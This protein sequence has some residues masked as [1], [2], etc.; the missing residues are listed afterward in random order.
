MITFKLLGVPVGSSFGRPVSIFQDYPE[1]HLFIRDT[2]RQ[3]R[4][5]NP[6]LPSRIHVAGLTK[7]PLQCDVEDL[8]AFA[9]LWGGDN[10]EGA[11]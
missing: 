6:A 1:P 7:T 11:S 4:I 9:H 5:I 8:A 3:W 10:F 2:V